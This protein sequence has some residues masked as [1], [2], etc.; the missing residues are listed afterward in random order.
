MFTLE[1]KDL[2]PQNR[3]RTERQ[4]GQMKNRSTGNTPDILFQQCP[5]GDGV[6]STGNNIFFI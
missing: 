4:Y 1:K 2:I 5:S 6:L 3:Y